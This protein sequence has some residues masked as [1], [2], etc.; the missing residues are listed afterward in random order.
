MG[1]HISSRQMMIVSEYVPYGVFSLCKNSFKLQVWQIL[2]P[3]GNKILKEE[4]YNTPIIVE[5]CV[6]GVYSYIKLNR[7]SSRLP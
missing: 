5:D 1:S 7:L 3:Q 2:G 6:H 4:I